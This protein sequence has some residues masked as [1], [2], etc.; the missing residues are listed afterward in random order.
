MELVYVR[1]VELEKFPGKWIFEAW[2]R[3]IKL[4]CN[5]EQEKNAK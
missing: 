4:R 5:D 2:K 1:L 3:R